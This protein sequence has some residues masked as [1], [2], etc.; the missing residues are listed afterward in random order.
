MFAYFAGNIRKHKNMC[1]HV[2]S[3]K[4]LESCVM[5]ARRSIPS[6]AHQPHSPAELGWCWKPNQSGGLA[7][8][9]VRC[10]DTTVTMKQKWPNIKNVRKR[11]KNQKSSIEKD[12]RRL[13]RLFLQLRLVVQ[14]IMDFFEAF[15]RLQGQP[16]LVDLRRFCEEDTKNRDVFL[17]RPPRYA[18]LIGF[19]SLEV[20]NWE[21]QRRSCAPNLKKLGSSNQILVALVLPMDFLS[22]RWKT[23]FGE[24]PVSERWKRSLA[25]ITWRSFPYNQCLNQGVVPW[26]NVHEFGTLVV[27]PWRMCFE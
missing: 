1:Y 16:R 27:K 17:K 19:R 21:L 15:P 9:P 4:F 20:R 23:W 13:L 18:H 11:Q 26:I 10:W 12:L 22:I 24:P 14:V 3:L 25:C 5:D 8:D 6:R 2:L 7:H